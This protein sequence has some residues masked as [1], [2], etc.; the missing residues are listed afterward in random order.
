MLDSCWIG[1]VFW[2]MGTWVGSGWIIVVYRHN[3]ILEKEHELV[4][5]R[6]LHRTELSS[7]SLWKQQMMMI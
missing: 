3:T 6:I 7:S 2:H 1:L 5:F 4:N